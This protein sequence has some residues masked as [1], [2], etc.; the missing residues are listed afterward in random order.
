[1]NDLLYTHWCAWLL[2]YSLLLAEQLHALVIRPQVAIWYRS[3]RRIFLSRVN[4]TL[5]YKWYSIVGCERIF[6]NVKYALETPFTNMLHHWLFL[7]RELY[8]WSKCSIILKDTI[9]ITRWYIWL[10]PHPKSLLG[11]E[12]D[13]SCNRLKIEAAFYKDDLVQCICHAIDD[14]LSSSWC[15]K[16]RNAR[17]VEVSESS[18]F[19][20]YVFRD[21][22]SCCSRLMMT[23]LS[24]VLQEWNMSHRREN[25]Q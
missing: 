8:P 1:M 21:K 17:W 5:L 3:M 18:T 4:T 11:K 16:G 22:H 20:W 24:L 23:I 6:G 10:L 25:T 14:T 9:S 15:E 19:S 13:S 12:N 2:I 7:K